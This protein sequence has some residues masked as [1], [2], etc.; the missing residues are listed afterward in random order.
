M[1]LR[2]TASKPVPP[3]TTTG[4]T[5]PTV[6]GTPVQADETLAEIKKALGQVVVT[7]GDQSNPYEV[8]GETV[9]AVRTHLTEA[10]SIHKD[11]KAYVNSEEVTGDTI[12]RAGD[13]L[14]FIKESGQ[15]G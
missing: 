3:A 5:P 7:H 1:A 9:A 2:T 15:K 6:Q 10:Y 8:A 12:L 14:E 11:A 4:N 13:E